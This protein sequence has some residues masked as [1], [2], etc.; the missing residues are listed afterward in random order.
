MRKFSN[1]FTLALALFSSGTGHALASPPKKT[2]HVGVIL[3][4][5][6][7]F[8]NSVSEMMT[9]LETAKN[10]FEQK[11]HVK[12]TLHRY[13]HAEELSTVAIAA[14]QAIKDKVPAVIGG[15]LSEESFVLRDKLG[16]KEIVFM[17]PT[18]SNPAVTDGFSF[19][20]RAC[21]SDKTV[22][23]KLA[24]FTEEKL[25]PKAIGVIHNISSP[26][27]DYLSKQFIEGFN[28]AKKEHSVSVPVFEEK[29]LRDT[30]DFS[31]QIKNFIDHK[32]THVVMLA[33]QT[34]LLRFA[35]Q[36]EKMNFFPTYVGSDGWGNNENVRKKLVLESP[37]GSKFIGFRNSYWKEE[38]PTKMGTEFKNQY[39]KLYSHD[40]SA[41]SAITFDAA[42][43]LFT[44]MKN[45]KDP[46]SGPSIREE[47]LKIKNIPLVTTQTFQFGP[48]NS[49]KKDLYIYRIDQ[50]GIKFE[51]TLK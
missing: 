28:V 8:N 6:D 45:A 3:R 40:P 33:H 7:K 15:E 18:S 30:M 20:F 29:I 11:N 38:T 9:G 2:L 34:D 22:A 37:N 46:T 36:A 44:A 49:P 10:L 42:I 23:E 5:D 39:R 21:F 50:S 16:P 43:I 48:D 12:I 51:G 17:T 13:A 24:Q 35:L 19:S 25:K 47:M 4:L 14:E 41:W 1:T 27:S 31:S 32:V 26:Y